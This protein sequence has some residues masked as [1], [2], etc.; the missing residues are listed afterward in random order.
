MET[1][2]NVNEFLQKYRRVY[3]CM[4]LNV[5]RPRIRCADG[6]T[7]SVQAGWGIYSAP[8]EDADCYTHVEVGY[9]SEHHGE[10]NE[11]SDGAGVFGFVPVDVVDKVLN[12]HGGI[13]GADFSN[14]GAGLWKDMY[15]EENGGGETVQTIY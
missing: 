15:D 1:K 10:F 13:V 6:Y 9:P 7:V 12:D 11:W 14:D 8:R 5:T 4:N 3:T 2:M